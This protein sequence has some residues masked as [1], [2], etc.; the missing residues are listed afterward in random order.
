MRTPPSDKRQHVPL[1]VK[2]WRA[3]HLFVIIGF[4]AGAPLFAGMTPAELIERQLGILEEN[5]QDAEA[6]FT[7]AQ[8]YLDLAGRKEDGFLEKAIVELEWLLKHDGERAPYLALLGSARTIQARD[9]IFYKKM[10]FLKDAEKLLDRAVELDSENPQVLLI[11]AITS[12]KLPRIFGRRDVAEA[13]FAT[14]IKQIESTPE[15]IEPFLRKTIYFHA[16][17]FLLDEK[18]PKSLT[19]LRKAQETESEMFIYETELQE[20]LQI[21]VKKFS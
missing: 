3:V 14:L 8:V 7:L 15:A 4:C 18:E 17:T 5:P 13:D 6:R 21:A 20:A 19:L 2:F 10:D 1:A 11:R 16:G 9:A 12:Y